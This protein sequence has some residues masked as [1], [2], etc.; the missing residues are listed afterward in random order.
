MHKRLAIIAACFLI[1]FIPAFGTAGA[2]SWVKQFVYDP[3]VSAQTREHCQRAVDAVDE[4]FT[5]YKIVVSTPITIVVVANDAESDIRALM[6]Y[7]NMTRAQA[8]AG[9]G[10]GLGRSSQTKSVILISNVPQFAIDPKV[11]LHVLSHELFHQVQY[12]YIGGKNYGNT[13]KGLPTWLQEGSAELFA[14]MA[15]ETAGFGSVTEHVQYLEQLIR[16][17]AKIPDTRELPYK[18][19]YF[20]NQGYP[21]YQIADL[22]TYRL[23]GDNGFGKVL[24]YCQLLNKGSDPDKTFVTA[25]GRPMS[26]FLAEMNE[27]FN[28]LRQPKKGIGTVGIGMSKAQ[29]QLVMGVMQGMPAAEAGIKIGDRILRVDG[30][31][32]KDL[33]PPQMVELLTGQAGSRVIIEVERQGETK[34][35]SFTLIRKARD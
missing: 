9:A 17:T 27:Y 31:D 1:M 5:K 3:S 28:N 26:D 15:A 32:A 13:A 11:D 22:M 21:L 35:L 4:L 7:F 33:T 34:P 23:V 24:L 16:K 20:L 10:K 2:A 29:P 8:E 25:F 6:L 14:D 12:Q 30:K 19:G 18:W